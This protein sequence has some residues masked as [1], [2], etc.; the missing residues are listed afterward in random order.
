MDD[1]LK[2]L[3]H[4]SK[5]NIFW[6]LEVQFSGEKGV[7]YGGLSAGIRKHKLP[8]RKRVLICLF[9]KKCSRCFSITDL[10]WTVLLGRVFLVL[11]RVLSINKG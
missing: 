4:L 10:F 3:Q 9:F 5:D 1:V 11:Q 8:R 2:G 7:D 6:R